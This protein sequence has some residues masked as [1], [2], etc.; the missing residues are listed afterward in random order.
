MAAQHNPAPHSPHVVKGIPWRVCRGCGLVYLRNP[1]TE[2]CIRQGCNH[3]EHPGY[4]SAVATLGRP[5]V[6]R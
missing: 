1:L 5:E 4:R 6:S 2:W 3:D